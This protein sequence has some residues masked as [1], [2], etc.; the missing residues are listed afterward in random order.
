MG[1]DQNKNQGKSQDKS[2]GQFRGV[3]SQGKGQDREHGQG[4]NEGDDSMAGN[5]QSTESPGSWNDRAQRDMQQGDLTRPAQ[6]DG[7]APLAKDEHPINKNRPV[8]QNR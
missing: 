5:D 4:R 8:Q 7:T 1:R 6:P 3:G 2:D